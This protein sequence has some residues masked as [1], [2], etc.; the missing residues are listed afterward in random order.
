MTLRTAT[1]LFS[2]LLLTLAAACVPDN[3]VP[4]AFVTV[5]DLELRVAG[6][7]DPSEA[8]TEVWVFVDN[9]FEGA[10]PLPARVPILR[11]GETE[12]RFEAG[13]RQNG[14]S[15]TPDIY[16]FYTPVNVTADL[17]PG[18]TLDLGVLTVSYRPEVKFA[19]FE[20][21]EDLSNGPV[22]SVQVAGEQGLVPTTERVRSGTQSG[23]IEL[24]ARDSLVEVATGR[25]LS[26][27]TDER[28][29]VWLEVDFLSD[30][31]I[32]WGVSG[33]NGFD[34][35]RSF[36]PIS[37]PRNEWT[38]I[39]FNLT[40][41]IILANVNEYTLNLSTLLPENLSEGKVYLDNIKL[42]HF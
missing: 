30:A 32:Q 8:I 34:I 9:V 16:E 22:F 28:L 23:V 26:G 25:F 39:Y 31:P 20:N 33:L 12:L 40:P 4:P 2:F 1:G 42:V 21:F 24:T 41:A 11:A 19:V 14:V 5:T 29:S 17:V 18:E 13:I 38:K 3:E 10:F 36:D 15:A 7:T 35:V 6:E 27:L 37:R